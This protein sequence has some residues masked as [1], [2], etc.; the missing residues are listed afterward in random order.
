MLID[1]RDSLIEWFSGAYVQ[2]NAGYIAVWTGGEAGGAA[3][4]H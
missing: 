3:W 4:F 1:T 2:V